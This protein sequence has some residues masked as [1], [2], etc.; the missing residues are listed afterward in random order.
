[1]CGHCRGTIGGLLIL[2]RVNAFGAMIL[3][4]P[5]L[6]LPGLA[7]LVV[8]GNDRARFFRRMHLPK[9]ALDNSELDIRSVWWSSGVPERKVAKDRSRRN[10]RLGDRPCRSDRCGRNALCLECPCDQPN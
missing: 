4:L 5:S 7:P 3:Q 6:V 1:M 8:K 2:R 9:R 10:D